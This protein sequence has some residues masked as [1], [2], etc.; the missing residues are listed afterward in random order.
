MVEDIGCG[1]QWDAAIRDA[2]ISSWSERYVY[3]RPGAG[4]GTGVV[5]ATVG[6][7]PATQS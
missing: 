5:D 3:L 1:P 2:S 6:G 7:T 4:T